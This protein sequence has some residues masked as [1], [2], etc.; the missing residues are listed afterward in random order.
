LPSAKL[1][2]KLALNLSVILFEYWNQA[3]YIQAGTTVDIRHRREVDCAERA[4]RS[5]CPGREN[6]AATFANDHRLPGFD[7]TADLPAE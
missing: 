5:R 6:L 1:V 3:R 4:N 7:W 2:N